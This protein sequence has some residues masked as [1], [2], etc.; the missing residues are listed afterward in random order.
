MINKQT[1]NQDQSTDSIRSIEE[2]LPT[3][4][5]RAR[6]HIH[7]MF[8]VDDFQR[9]LDLNM[10]IL[11]GTVNRFSG[12]LSEKDRENLE[13][14]LSADMLMLLEM[15]RNLSNRGKALIEQANKVIE[16]IPY[17]DEA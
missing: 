2:A 12:R 6:D 11:S 10:S 1:H 15:A 9:A 8:L 5:E 17:W 13:Y 3:M 16:K 7:L 4:K 14:K